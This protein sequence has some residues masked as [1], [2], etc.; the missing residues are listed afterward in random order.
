MSKRNQNG[1]IG[2]ILLIVL[3]LVMLGGAGAF[4][5][6]SYS[7]EQK[8]KNH[9]DTLIAAAVAQAKQKQQAT[10][11]AQYAEEAKNP[12]R[13]YNGPQA[14]GSVV[15][16][17]P[18]TWSAFVDDTGTGSSLINGY[19][20]PG[21][22]PSTYAAGSV[23]S[24]RV[25]LLQQ[26]YSQV[27]NNFQGQEAAGQITS[28][29]AYALPKV[30]NVVGVEIKGQLGNGETGTMVVLPLRSNTLEISTGGSQFLGDFNNYIL[31]NFSFSP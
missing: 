9:A 28:I 2:I 4:A 15:I 13:T 20:A 18:K 11:S 16:A 17:Y 7:G 1:G 5:A 31:P 24:L 30:P 8:Y 10:D 12:L 27:V 6:S 23:F 3:L 29:T 14:Y 21:T 26:T 22:V 19:F 25:Q